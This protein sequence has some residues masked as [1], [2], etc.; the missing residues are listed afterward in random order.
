MPAP[1]DSSKSDERKRVVLQAAL[2]CFARKGFYGTTTHEIA[3]QAGISQPY[4]YRLFA[5]KE[6]LFVGVV[7]LVS[8][9]M[10]STVAK[11]MGESSPSLRTPTEALDAARAAY[12]ALIEN[13]DVMMF[14]MHANCAADEPQVAAAVRSCYAAQVR[15]VSEL[16]ESDED[17]IR[18]WFGA[19]MLDNIV[20]ALHLSEV[21][22][23]WART[24]RG[25]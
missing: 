6:T 23:P 11:H 2:V 24:L 16:L 7:E 8:G 10:N 17:A 5:N 1:G 14:L 21:D 25:K 4:L 12:G 13:R 3:R 19:G 15:V 9:L 22:E 18:Q 20:L